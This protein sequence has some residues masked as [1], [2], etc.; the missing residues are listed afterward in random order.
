M[1]WDGVFVNLVAQALLKF[2]DKSF[3]RDVVKVVGFASIVDIFYDDA[4]GHLPAMPVMQPRK[5]QQSK[6]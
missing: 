1:G 5:N 6:Y 4:G 2:S 3:Q